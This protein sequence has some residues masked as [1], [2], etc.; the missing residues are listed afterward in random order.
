MLKRIFVFLIS[1]LVKLFSVFPVLSFTSD[2]KFGAFELNLKDTVKEQLSKWRISLFQ[3]M[4]GTS[5][6]YLF[7]WK[8]EFDDNAQKFRIKF[9]ILKRLSLEKIFDRK[10]HIS[11]IYDKYYARLSGFETS[12]GILEKRLSA[13]K[14]SLCYHIE[15]E[16]NRIESSDN[17]IV[18]YTT[19]VLTV[20]PIIVGLN[21]DY[22]FELFVQNLVFTILFCVAIYAIF[23]VFLYFYQYIKVGS[24]S[25]S[26]FSD[27]KDTITGQLDSK[28]TAQYYFDY[29]SLKSRAD[30]FVSYVKNIQY[31]MISLLIV[32]IAIFSYHKF[33]TYDS[34]TYDSTIQIISNNS[35]CIISNIEVDKLTDPYSQSSIKL[36]D[37]K[38]TVQKKEADKLIIII[39]GKTDYEI[40][41]KEL[42]LFEDSFEIQY[43][44]DNELEVDNAKILIYKGESVK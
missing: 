39:N 24:Y 15:S 43:V 12:A 41:K 10:E 32:F 26:S 34:I 37:I 8:R 16:K 9:N 7:T 6:L 38:R 1:G 29:Q 36:T 4:L 18:I 27:L 28:I 42:L 44:T 17:K 14:E 3:I 13:E 19:V 11:M 23:N 20:L 5:K 25:M 31:W 30:L 35:N 2:E 40:I 33:I 21:F 22:I